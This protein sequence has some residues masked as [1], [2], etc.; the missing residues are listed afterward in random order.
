MV[1]QVDLI[2]DRPFKSPFMRAISTRVTILMSYILMLQSK[3][4]LKTISH[5]FDCILVKHKLDGWIHEVFG[6]ES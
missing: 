1:Y 4:K 5:D 6:F 2:H 3:K